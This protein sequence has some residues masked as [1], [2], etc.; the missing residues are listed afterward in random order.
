[1]AGMDRDDMRLAGRVMEALRLRDAHAGYMEMLR[2]GAAASPP[3]RPGAIAEAQVK[4]ADLD[5]CLSRVLRRVQV[6]DDTPEPLVRLV[7]EERSRATAPVR[8]ARGRRGG[9]AG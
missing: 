6:K 2:A 8:Q 3:G 7:A 1:M 4:A 9:S 5:A